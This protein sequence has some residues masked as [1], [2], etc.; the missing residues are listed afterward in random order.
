MSKLET[1]S[2][3]QKP[4]NKTGHKIIKTILLFLFLGL[5]TFGGIYLYAP[6]QNIEELTSDLSN[7]KHTQIQYINSNIDI[8]P[9]IISIS[10]GYIIKNNTA[11]RDII[12]INILTKNKTNNI[13]D[14]YINQIQILTLTNK[15]VA[16]AVKT[17]PLANNTK[18][19]EIYTKFNELYTT[20]IDGYNYCVSNSKKLAQYLTKPMYKNL[21][22]EKK[23]QDI[24]CIQEL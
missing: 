13:S 17:P 7:H 14:I 15:I 19:K 8:V 2:K 18:F 21:V 20:A 6:V 22:T 5:I 10:K 12:Q 24:T 9:K 16:E 3:V 11:L 4:Q 1:K 23:L